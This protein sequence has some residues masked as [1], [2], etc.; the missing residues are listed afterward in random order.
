M[1]N[2]NPF[3]GRSILIV[4]DE[5]LIAMELQ[6]LFESAGAKVRCARTVREA[7][8]L[9][10]EGRLCAAVLDY[11][12]GAGDVSQ[13]CRQLRQQAI[14]FVFYSGY[15]AA[16]EHPGVVFVRKPSSGDTLLSAVCR[17]MDVRTAA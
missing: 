16:E 13:L 17:L 12:V 10:A 6:L 5:P 4:E 2:T 1:G 8:E 9:V 3:F 7:L 15:D 11:S 14:P